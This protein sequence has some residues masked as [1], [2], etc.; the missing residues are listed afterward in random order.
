M[1][2]RSCP[3]RRGPAPTARSTTALLFVSV[4]LAPGLAAQEAATPPAVAPGDL[5]LLA[6]PALVVAPATGRIEVDGRLDEAAW[7]DVQVIADFVQAE[8]VAGAPPSERTEAWVTFDEDHLYIA[9]RMWESDIGALVTGGMERDV[10]GILMEEMDA[11]GVTL[12]TFLDRRNSFIFF[13]NPVGGLKD[14]QGADDGRSRDYGWNGVVDVRTSI[15]DEGW[16]VEMA[17]P[18]RTLRYDPSLPEQE[19]G[20]NLSRRIRRKNEVSYWA[21]LDRRNRIFLMSRAGTMTGI[22]QLPAS[23]NLNV[24]PFT[25]ASRSSG[26]SLPDGMAGNDFDGG[27]DLKYGLTPSLTLDLTWR[28][29]FSQ[30]EVDAQQVDLTRF[31]VF[32]PELREFFLENSGTF[33]FGDLES[34]PGGPRLGTSLRDF[35]LFHSRQIGLRGGRPVPLTGGGRITGRAAGMEVGLLNVQSEALDGRPGE[36]FSVVR[37]RRDLGPNSNVGFMFT[38]RDPTGNPEEGIASTPT[39]RAVG[40]D[41]NLRFFTNLWVNSYLAVTDAGDIRDH[42]AR[43]AVGWRDPYWNTAISYRRIGDDFTPGIGFVRRRGIHQGYVT[44]GRHHRPANPRI[45]EINPYVEHTRITNLEGELES[46]SYRGATSFNLADRSSVNLSANRQFERLFTPFQIRPGTF[47]PEGDYHFAEG[48]LSYR[49]SQ[50]KALSGN[51]GVSGG[52]FYD[53]TRF[54]VTGGLRWAPDHRLILDLDATHNALE[55]Q[56]TRFSADL[57]SARF[58]YAWSTVLNFTGFVQYNADIDEVVTNLRL[59]YVHAPLS[60]LFLL[61]TERRPAGGGDAGA[62]ERFVTVKVTRLLV[63]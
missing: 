45:T 14:G 57:Y 53:G 34:G 38:N 59:N 58:Q 11:F 63:F 20:L 44:L 47:I 42:A 21:P 27:I 19:W 3:Y 5:E 31:P 50:G 18:W 25:L 61:Y 62:L 39:N 16:T 52:E 17:I 40:V 51:V 6:R 15:D 22:G 37:L 49:S 12:D 24:K 56:D 48:S 35:T 1:L 2:H 41:A 55:V 33:S 60:D 9:A 26:S 8:P 46:A 32:F 29:D 7:R 4:S 54:S 10:P 30:V 13:V 23:R 43:L 36:N 28:T